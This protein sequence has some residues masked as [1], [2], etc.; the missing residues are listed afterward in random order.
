VQ[1]ICLSIFYYTLYLFETTTLLSSLPNGLLMPFTDA[2]RSTKDGSVIDFEVSPGSKSVEVP[3]GYNQ[4]RK[5][6]EV[7]LKAQ[8]EKG[9]ANDELIRAL[10]DIFKI[11]STSVG[12]SGATNSRKTVL[13]R[14]ISAEAVAKGLGR[15]TEWMTA[16]VSRGSSRPSTN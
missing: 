7:R 12:A 5:R 6:I 11:P 15:T 13:I 4:W 10:A 2:I 16:N 8:P 1:I 3:S 14:G 9:K